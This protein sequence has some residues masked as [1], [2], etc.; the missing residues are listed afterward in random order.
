MAIRIP[1]VSASIDS[2]PQQ[3]TTSTTSYCSLRVL[4]KK[5][6]H[7]SA[8]DIRAGWQICE[9]NI[10]LDFTLTGYIPYALLGYDCHLLW[11]GNLLYEQCLSV[12]TTIHPCIIHCK[13]V[14]YNSL[15]FYV[16]THACEMIVFGACVCLRL[17]QAMEQRIK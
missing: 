9:N 3:G 2:M 4:A 6:S 15:N 8:P 16:S 13:V 14:I 11:I 17:R 7:F 10:T 5:S 12:D 1:L